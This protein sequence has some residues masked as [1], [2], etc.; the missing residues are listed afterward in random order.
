MNQ[1]HLNPTSGACPFCRGT[2]TLMFG[3]I[4]DDPQDDK[5]IASTANI[6]THLIHTIAFIPFS[7]KMYNQP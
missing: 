4:L 1:Y 7:F 3:E 2:P 6:N 5:P